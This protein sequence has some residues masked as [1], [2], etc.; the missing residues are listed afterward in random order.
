LLIV[1]EKLIAGYQTFVSADEFAGAAA[2][3]PAI[4]PTIT[5]SLLSVGSASA[6]VSVAAT[7]DHGC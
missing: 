4:T 3:V 6:G 5:V 2:A 1:N 7:I